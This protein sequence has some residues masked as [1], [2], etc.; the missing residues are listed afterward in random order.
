MINSEV[1]WAEVTFINCY[2]YAAGTPWLTLSTS[3]SC[4]PPKRFIFSSGN[5]FQ[6][7]PF[8]H[9]CMQIWKK[10]Q[11]VGSRAKANKL[12]STKISKWKRLAFAGDDRELPSTIAWLDRT[13][14]KEINTCV[15]N[16]SCGP[17]T[18]NQALAALKW[19]RSIQDRSL[20]AN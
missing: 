2:F 5:T 14:A 20:R 12:E 17:S 3:W 19:T 9:T 4:K 10:R 8:L 1:Q 6:I 18:F 15:S 11:K 13:L 7:F 16:W